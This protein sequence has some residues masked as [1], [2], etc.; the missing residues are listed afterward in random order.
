[1]GYA[2]A[3][4]HPGDLVYIRETHVDMKTCDGYQYLTSPVSL[5][6]RP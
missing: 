3:K 5:V 2:A 4:F 6:V 1:M